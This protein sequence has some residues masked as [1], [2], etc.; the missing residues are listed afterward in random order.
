MANR[1]LANASS[2]TSSGGSPMPIRTEEQ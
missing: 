2:V 1:A